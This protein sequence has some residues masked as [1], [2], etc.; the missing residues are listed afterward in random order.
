MSQ[1]P[2]LAVAENPSD[3]FHVSGQLLVSFTD[4]FKE[5]L[6]DVVET[7]DFTEIVHPEQSF[8]MCVTYDNIKNYVLDTTL[9]P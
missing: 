3:V 2:M 9:Q 5:C 6:G 4:Q 8:V 7:G 1:Q